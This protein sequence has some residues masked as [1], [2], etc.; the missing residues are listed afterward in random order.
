MTEAE[1][2]RRVGNPFR[3]RG[4][5]VTE[6]PET[7]TETPDL[8]LEKNEQR[9]LL[10]IKTKEDDPVELAEFHDTLQRG[11]VAETALPFAPQNTIS[12]VVRKGASQLAAF[13]D[14]TDPFRLLW[15]LAIGTDA[16]GQYE[17][18]RSTLYGLTNVVGPDAVPLMPCYFLKHSAFFRWRASLDGAIIATTRGAELLLNPLS[19]RCAALAQSEVAQMFQPHVVDPL[20]LERLGHAYVADCEIDR[21]NENE[22]LGYVSGKYGRPMLMAMNLGSLTAYIEIPEQQP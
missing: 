18:F 2:K 7:T 9:F 3:D 16:K 11:G 17:Q 12:G 21:N 4:F 19:G 14:P 5:Q 6:I 10:E 1:V 8:L 20:E 13:A 22:V 15:L